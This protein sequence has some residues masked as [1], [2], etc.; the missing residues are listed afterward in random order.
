MKYSI[1]GRDSD[2]EDAI[3]RLTF[4]IRGGSTGWNGRL[5]YLKPEDT[6]RAI[7][8]RDAFRYRRKLVRAKAKAKAKAKENAN[9]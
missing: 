6:E 7:R 1:E 2:L 9:G 3:A 5:L 4:F 8:T